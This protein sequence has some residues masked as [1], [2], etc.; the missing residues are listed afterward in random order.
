MKEKA[1][2]ML[3]LVLK[4]VQSIVASLLCL[5][6]LTCTLTRLDELQLTVETLLSH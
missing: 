6:N 5:I 1:A 4:V 2:D 3:C